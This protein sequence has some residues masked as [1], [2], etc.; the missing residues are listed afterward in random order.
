MNR[1]KNYTCYCTR[2]LWSDENLDKY[3]C[4]Y[5]KRAG[6]CDNYNYNNTLCTIPNCYCLSSVYGEH[7]KWNIC[8]V[9]CRFIPSVVTLLIDTIVFVPAIIADCKNSGS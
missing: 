6:F 1:E 4:C 8:S 2:T 9:V 7:R 5:E 3:G